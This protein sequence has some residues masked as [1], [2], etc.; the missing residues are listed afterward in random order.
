MSKAPGSAGVLKRGG[1]TTWPGTAWLLARA[2]WEVEGQG[3]GQPGQG[4]GQRPVQ[5]AVGLGEQVAA[6]GGDRAD[7]ERHQREQRDDH[8]AGHHLEPQL[9]A[10]QPPQQRC[11]VNCLAMTLG[12]DSSEPA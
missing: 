2:A 1:R 5:V 8:H 9:G 10:E 11:R 3:G 6:H 12:Y 4:Q 7:V